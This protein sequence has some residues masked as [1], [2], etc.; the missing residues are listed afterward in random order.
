LRRGTEGVQCRITS[1]Q[2]RDVCREKDR[3]H[4]VSSVGANP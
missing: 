1:E 4:G 2:R 3:L